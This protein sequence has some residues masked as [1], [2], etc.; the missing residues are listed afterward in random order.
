MLNMFSKK[1][2]LFIAVALVVGCLADLVMLYFFGK[3]IPGYN[4]FTSTISSLGES[5][6]PVA[7]AVTAWS[8]TLG[9]IFIFFGFAF[10]SVY[11][12][13]GIPT[14]FASLLL[15]IYGIGENIA[16][17]V[18]KPDHINGALTFMAVLHGI[19]GGIG[20]ISALLLPFIMMKLFTRNSFPVF[21]VFSFFVLLTG[22]VSI[23]LFSFR[24]VY[25]ENS[26]VNTYKGLWQRIFLID[27][28]IYF[29]AIAFMMIKKVNVNASVAK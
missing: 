18:F 8:V 7:G 1:V 9:I 22:L 5:S 12:E 24:V 11:Y 20:V 23:L 15:I 14:R 25:F 28:Y 4:Q 6:S 26:F 19:L 16:S 27:Y 3:Q 2:S 13:Y 17:G 29:A 10:R 21:Y